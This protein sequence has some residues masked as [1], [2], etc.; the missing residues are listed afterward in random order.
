MQH[1]PEVSG[2]LAAALQQ[3]ARY[4]KCVKPA[5]LCAECAESKETEV[6][7]K[8]LQLQRN[9]DDFFCLSPREKV[10]FLFI[11]IKL[12][13]DFVAAGI[14]ILRK[15]KGKKLENNVSSTFCIIEN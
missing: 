6:Y 14:H 13:I 3:L 2:E 7:A 11:P 12:C 8:I 5:L 15:S 9:A 4:S 1:P 10:C